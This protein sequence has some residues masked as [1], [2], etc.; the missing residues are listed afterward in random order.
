MVVQE[1]FDPRTNT[2][3]YI[4]Y[5]QDQSSCL[6]IDPVLDLNTETNTTFTESADKLIAYLQQNNL[7]PQYILETH[8]HADHLTSSA[9]L[10]SKFPLAKIVI[11]R[12]VSKV[13]EVFNPKFGLKSTPFDFDLLVKDGDRFDTGELK[14]EVLETPG[15]TPACVTFKIQDCLFTGDV[16]FMPDSG[17]G[18]CDFPLGSAGVLYQSIQKIYA[19]PESTKIYVGHDYQPEGRALMFKTTVG[20]QK[21]KNIHLNAGVSKDQYV[22]FRESRDKAL[23]P[24][25]LLEPSLRVNLRAGRF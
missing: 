20:E 7:Q 11:G 1:F 4:V 10:K 12:G 5:N 2:L 17:T 19:L 14:V 22:Q 25:K 16:L 9:Y 8:V 15:H 3:T 23:S 13:Q 21:S 18:R 24:P 6:I